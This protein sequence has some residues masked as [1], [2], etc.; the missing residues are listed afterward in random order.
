MKRATPADL[1][2]LMEARE[3]LA[4]R[5]LDTLGDAQPGHPAVRRAKEILGVAVSVAPVPDVTCRLHG[6]DWR[7]CQACS[8]TAASR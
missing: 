6:V 2:L 3:R 5:I 7:T 4:R 1:R 8:S